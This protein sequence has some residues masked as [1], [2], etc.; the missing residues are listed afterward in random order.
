[1]DS[2]SLLSE[3]MLTY[4]VA[5]LLLIVAGRL[6]VPSIVALIVTGVIAGPFGAA[7]VATQERVE[8]LAEVG[9]VLL[10]FMVGLEF[11][12]GDLRRYWRSVIFGGA[13]Q[14]GLTIAAG[15]GVVAL[16]RAGSF[17]VAIFV[18]VFA[19]LSS[20]AIVLQELT[21]RNQA[22]SF[23]GQLGT[24]VL[25]FQDLM[26][27]VLLA[28]QPLAAGQVPA[29]AALA[30]VGSTLLALV[31][32]AGVGWVL[33]P[34]LL[35]FAADA[36]SRD[37]FTLAVLLASVGTAWLT[38][39]FGV[40]M[41]LGAFLG[42]LVLGETEFSHQIHAELRPL[43][44]AL[45]SLFFISMGMLINPGFVATSAAPIVATAIL[46]IA[47]K[48]AAAT[49]AFL[50]VG[51]PLRVAVTAG[52]MLA[53]VGEFS[54]LLGNTAVQTGVIT[55]ELRQ[56]LLA[57]GVLTMVA[58]PML[59][60]YAPALGNWVARKAGRRMPSHKVDDLAQ[61]LTGHVVIVGYGVGG[62][63]LATALREIGQPYL[64]LD[65]NAATVREAKRTGEL[66]YFGD[67][68][69][70]DALAVA[71]IDSALAVVGLMSDPDASMRLVRSVREISPTL[72]ILMRTRYRAEAEQLQRAGATLAIAEELEASLEVLAQLL[73]RLHI[74]GNLITVLLENLRRNSDARIR[75]APTIPFRAMPGQLGDMPV[76]THRIS[77]ADWSVGRTLGE[78][79][80]RAQTGA[81]VLA[82]QKGETY[83]T[84]PNAAVVLDTGDVLYLTGDDSDVQLARARLTNG[85]VNSSPG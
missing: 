53:Q 24:G 65:L 70:R 7:F 8:L 77:D 67:A 68:S 52:T 50:L 14:M 45:A 15:I 66:I 48:A 32:A 29:S 11:S 78:V 20:T 83:V 17:R 1:M 46:I 62:R 82:V 58:T 54:F 84:S 38:S 43:R 42:G 5:L 51:S 10:L 22:D 3:L 21:R 35:R 27:I 39:L 64:I 37:A 56:I 18:G 75:H 26:I 41:A 74:P 13:L 69:N 16:W 30:S 2:H 44:D 81:T 12:I 72:T 19:A 59:V 85:L 47:L 60:A 73:A 40:S 25:L 33:L 9:I 79:D 6:R 57:A 71:R 34:R 28:L 31:L 23:P 80:L 63:L 55:N 76:A 49:A 4:G 61:E 36:R